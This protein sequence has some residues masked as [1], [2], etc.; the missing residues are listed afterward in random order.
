MWV[1]PCMASSWAET[2]HGCDGAAVSRFG[3]LSLWEA[4]SLHSPDSQLEGHRAQQAGFS[5]PLTLSPMGPGA[6]VNCASS[7]PPP[8]TLAPPTPLLPAPA[9]PGGEGAGSWQPPQP[10]PYK[11]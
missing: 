6:A 1:F 11:A 2:A 8:P 10:T 5:H 4:T 7:P 9:A 3:S